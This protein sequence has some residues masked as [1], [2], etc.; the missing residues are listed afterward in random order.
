MGKDYYGLLEVK[1]D[2]SEEEIKKAYKKMVSVHISTYR[3]RSPTVFLPMQTFLVDHS[4]FM[5]N[6]RP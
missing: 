3:V 2:A 4:F 5:Y 1:K 6:N